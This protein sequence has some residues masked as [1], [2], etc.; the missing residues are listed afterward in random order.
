MKIAYVHN[1][2]WPSDSPSMTF[3]T[4]N[5]IGL[6]DI[7][8]TC[9]LFIKKNSN[10]TST[11]ICKEYFS[12]D[13][14]DNLIIH[15]ISKNKILNT[16]YFYFRRV[17]RELLDIINKQKLDC[18]ISRNVGFL[19]YLVKIT[20]IFG[21][22]TFFETHDFYANLSVRDDINKTKKRK[23]EK[24]EKTYIPKINGI[25]CLQNSQKE[26]Y[27]KVFPHQNIHIARTG[28]AKIQPHEFDE[29]Q[30][31]AYIGSV[32]EHKGIEVLIKAAGLSKTK[33]HVLIVGGKN[34]QEKAA[35]TDFSKKNYELNRVTV[36]G[37]VN[38]EALEHY[39]RKIAVGVIPLNDTFFNK[40][41]T[42]P[43]KLFDFYS[44]GIPVIASNLPTMRELVIENQLGLFFTPGHPEDLAQK[45]DLLFSN[46]SLLK[47]MS[48]NIIDT[49]PQYLWK[50]RAKKIFDI[51]KHTQN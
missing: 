29:S 12:I 13:K 31:I 51:L 26:W 14:P 32:D 50:N 17:Y 3:V 4:Y 36:T 40:Y 34:A 5:A 7:F 6:A 8:D 35:I 23:N 37:W 19:P 49:A 1:G 48:Q 42:S 30:Y 38:R 43:L 24:I 41:I 22:K 47:T 10:H 33:P 45:I 39:L 18:I 16:N 11:E 28:I 44:H 25:I 20:S 46:P 2:L 21:I 15:S 9:H 27:Q